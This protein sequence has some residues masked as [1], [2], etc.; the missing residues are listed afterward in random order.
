MVTVLTMHV[1]LMLILYEGI[2][3][4]LPSPLV[5]NNVDL[6]GGGEN[7][8]EFQYVGNLW[9]CRPKHVILTL[10]IGP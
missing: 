10:L 7:Q 5:V 2:A 1:P 3:S 6:K 9:A 8:L 4:G